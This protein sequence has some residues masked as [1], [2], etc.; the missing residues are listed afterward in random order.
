M[1]WLDCSEKEFKDKLREA[2]KKAGVSDRNPIWIVESGL[3]NS[4]KYEVDELGR[5]YRKDKK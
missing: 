1:N 4:E 2:M 3:Q 5:V